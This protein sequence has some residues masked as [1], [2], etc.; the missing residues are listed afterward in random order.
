MKTFNDGIELIFDTSDDISRLHGKFEGSL[1][2]QISPS[3]VM[4]TFNDGIKLIFDTSDDI[5][6][7]HKKFEGSLYVQ[8]SHSHSPLLGL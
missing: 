1:Y 6:R 4:K 2:I 5:S 3:G 8:I 7:L